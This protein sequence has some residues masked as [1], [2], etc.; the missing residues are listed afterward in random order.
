MMVCS[1]VKVTSPAPAAAISTSVAQSS[2]APRS[3]FVKRAEK[4]GE[5]APG[6]VEFQCLLVSTSHFHRHFLRADFRHGGV[7]GR[8]FAPGVAADSVA[9]GGEQLLRPVAQRL[10]DD[11]V[12]PLLAEFGTQ[13][14]QHRYE[15]L[16]LDTR[17]VQKRQLGIDQI[18]VEHGHRCSSLRKSFSHRAQLKLPG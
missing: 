18:V 6:H 11:R 17:L 7:H 13:R 12:G 10:F 3:G 5:A 15:D 16:G 4:V 2:S 8:P 9:D 14:A 1:R